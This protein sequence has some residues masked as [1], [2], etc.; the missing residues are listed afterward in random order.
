MS[1]HP[2]TASFF[3][4]SRCFAQSILQNIH[5]QKNE[6]QA[7]NQWLAGLIDGD[8]CFIISSQGYTS[9]EIT[10]DLRDEHALQQIKSRLGGSVKL[11]SGSK[12]IRYRLHHKAGMLELLH[13]VNGE[14]R[15]SI[16]QKQFQALCQIYAFGPVRKPEPLRKENS[17]FAGFFDADGTIN[18]GRSGGATAAKAVQCSI[19]V[20]A[21]YD[22]VLIPFV[23]NFGGGI[24]PCKMSRTYKWCIQS[25]K[26]TLYFLECLK[27]FG[28]CRSSK[29][30][31][32]LAL[33]RFY[34]L[35]EM[36]AYKAE[37]GSLQLKAWNTFLEKWNS[38]CEA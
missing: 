17:W 5:N 19:S 37:E 11:R 4:G 26:D 24:Y 15:H 18:I 25:K 23:E 6:E 36:R 14:I 33:P 20:S 3:F 29:Q 10:M 27:S 12:S 21:K 22:D 35:L 31:R 7:W 38:R 1:T 32:F 13:R 8:G 2:S 9:C 28:P 34:E 30:Y 16:R